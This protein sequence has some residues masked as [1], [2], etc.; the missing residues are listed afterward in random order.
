MFYHVK[1]LEFNA[2]VSGPDPRFASLLLEQFGGPNGELK[3]AMQYFTQAFAARKPYP[4]KYDMLMDI[5]TEELSHLE[6]VGA[7]ITMLLDGVNG[8]LKNASESTSWMNLLPNQKEQMIHQAM[9]NPQFLL[10]SG[11]APRLTDSQGTPWMGSFV[12]ANGDLTV[13]LR[14]DIAAESRAKIVYEH[15]MQFTDDPYVKETLGF[16]MTREIA[17][18]KMF[19][20]ALETIEPNFPPGV[21]QGDPRY[22]HVYM[23]MSNGA[24]ARGPWNQ[25]QGAWESGEEWEYVQKPYEHVVETKGMVEQ[26]VKGNKH[27]L[28]EAQEKS[29]ALGKQ[30]S[31]EVK[32]SVGGGANQWSTYP[33]NDLASPKTVVDPE[34][35]GSVI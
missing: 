2:R 30:R 18:Y 33:Q 4:D 15:L 7:T 27:T 5:A 28:D 9:T 32:S 13:D 6:I 10:L 23:N 11:G 1:E 12:N 19:A 16:L 34:S 17:H 25:G 3:A 24:D 14:S 31:Q 21:L 29:R 26:P 20:S 8:E 35:H 22:T